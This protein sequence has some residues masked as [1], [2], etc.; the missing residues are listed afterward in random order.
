MG[1]F[2]STKSSKLRD[3][4]PVKI[5]LKNYISS[6]EKRYYIPSKSFQLYTTS[7]YLELMP[8]P[9]QLQEFKD[10]QNNIKGLSHFPTLVSRQIEVHANHFHGD[11]WLGHE[12]CLVMAYF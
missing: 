7:I 9:I 1:K 6:T 10:G 12:H 3:I 11:H 4:L 2:H 8:H 5:A